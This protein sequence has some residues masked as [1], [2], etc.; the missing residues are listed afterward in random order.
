[1]N[2]LLKGNSLLS[3]QRSFNL[4]ELWK[5]TAREGSEWVQQWG[6]VNPVSLQRLSLPHRTST[7]RTSS[8]ADTNGIQ[9]Q[10]FKDFPSARTAKRVKGRRD[11]KSVKVVKEAKLPTQPGQSWLCT[12]TGDYTANFHALEP[13]N[14]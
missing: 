1:M 11:A 4:A 13:P 9:W 5:A 14:P 3:K 8:S 2:A 6:L 7:P 10:R 12:G